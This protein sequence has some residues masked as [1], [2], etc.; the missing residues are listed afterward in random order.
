MENFKDKF[1]SFCVV[2]GAIVDIV[3][4]AGFF[5]GIGH[6]SVHIL[7]FALGTLLCAIFFINRK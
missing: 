2:L 6:V 1:L 4:V 3:A 5:I 7:L